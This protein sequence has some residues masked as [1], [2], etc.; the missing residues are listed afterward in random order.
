MQTKEISDSKETSPILPFFESKDEKIESKNISFKAVGDTIPGTNYPENKLIDDEKRLFAAIQETLSGAD[1]LFGNFES[2]LTEY[3][4]SGKDVSR[5][6]TYAFRTPPAYANLLKSVGFDVMSVVNN[7]SYDFKEAGFLDTLRN[8]NQAGI[9]AVGG[10][11]TIQYLNKKG[12]KIAFI[13]FSYQTYHNS[14]TRMEEAEVLVKEAVANADIVVLSIHAGAEANAIH[15][16]DAEEIFL[17]ENRGNMVKFSHRMIDLGADL[18]LGHGPHVPRGMEIYKDR[19]IAYSLGNFMGYRSLSSKG[20]N[21][22][23]LVLEVLVDEQGGFVSG[24]IHPVLM[25]DP[26]IPFPDPEKKSIRFIRQLSKEDFPNSPLTID[27]E[28]NVGKITEALPG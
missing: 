5:P 9:L 4:H 19:L 13:G 22:L 3:P 17:G 6:N 25:K 28:G 2:T 20:D 23:S 18:V 1:I 16:P 21:G 8:L 26:G 24:K 11:N 14:I 15:T 12:K 7:H 27:E 10:K